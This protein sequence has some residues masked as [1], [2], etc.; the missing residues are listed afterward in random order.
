ARHFAALPGVSVVR[1]HYGDVTFAPFNGYHVEIAGPEQLGGEDWAAALRQAGITVR[2]E[3]VAPDAFKQGLPRRGVPEDM[4]TNIT[5]FHT[6]FYDGSAQV[7]EHATSSGLQGL[8]GVPG[9]WRRFAAF[10]T[11]V[12]S[13]CQRHT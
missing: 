7:A 1:G 13:S 8:S 9:P 3:K 11:P 2:Y 12:F 10:V 5:A 4:A 6:C